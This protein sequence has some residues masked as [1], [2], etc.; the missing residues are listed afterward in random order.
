MPE[1]NKEL[2]LALPKGGTFRCGPSTD[3]HRWGDYVRICSP[4]G[5]ELFYWSA[6]EWRDEPESVMG[7]IIR[8]CI[9]N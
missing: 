5:E 1:A 3:S 6:D 2:I 4:N 9:D 7:D 8:A